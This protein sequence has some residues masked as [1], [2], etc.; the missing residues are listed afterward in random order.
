[1]ST[2]YQSNFL[3]VHSLP[4]DYGTLMDLVICKREAGGLPCW[5]F[6]DVG[7]HLLPS[8][9][10]VRVFFLVTPNWNCGDVAVRL[11]F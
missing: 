2:G 1:M 7:V 5:F 9:C 3:G 4:S 11:G 6:A 8:D 10:S